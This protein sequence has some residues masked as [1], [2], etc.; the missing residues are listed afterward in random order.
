L[1]ANTTL[2]DRVDP[3]TPLSLSS[4]PATGLSA[5][6]PAQRAGAQRLRAWPIATLWCEAEFGH[7]RGHSG[8]H[9]KIC[10]A[11]TVAIDP[12]PTCL[13]LAASTSDPVRNGWN[14]C[15]GA[16]DAR[17]STNRTSHDWDT[18]PFQQFQR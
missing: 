1:H 7:D 4:Q 18:T 15:G 14:C 6:A 17:S 12:E 3:A 9:R 8:H 10:S 16:V 11:S 2:V 13:A 5:L